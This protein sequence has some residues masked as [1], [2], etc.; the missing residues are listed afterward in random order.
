MI[1]LFVPAKD[2]LEWAHESFEGRSVNRHDTNLTIRDD[3]G[4]TRYVQEKS[5]LTEIITWLILLYDLCWLAWLEDF[6][7]LTLT[8][9]NHEELIAILVTLAND[10]VTFLE[11][12]FLEGVGELRPLLLLHALENLYLIQEVVILF[13]LLLNCALDDIVESVAIK[14]PQGHVSLGYDSGCTRSVVQ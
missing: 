1:L 3:V 14:G 2:F 12:F 8:F 6:G 10:V 9:D 5:T 13:S 4:G 11:P 7:C